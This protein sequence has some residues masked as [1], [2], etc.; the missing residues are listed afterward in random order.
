M[1][2]AHELLYTLCLVLDMLATFQAMVAAHFKLAMIGLLA[3]VCV[4]LL[5]CAIYFSEEKRK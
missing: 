4:A 5:G 1:E 2:L 3:F